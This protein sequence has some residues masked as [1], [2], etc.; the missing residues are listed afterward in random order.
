MASTQQTPFRFGHYIVLEVLGE[1]SFGTVAKCI[2]TQTLEVVAIKALKPRSNVNNEVEMLREVR[3]SQ[4]DKYNIVRFIEYFSD[5]D[6]KCIAFETLDKS[7]YQFIEDRNRTL[8]L[9]E[10]R[11]ITQQLL[12]AFDSLKTAGIMHADLK[13]DNVMLVNHS[14][15]PF[16]VKLIDF[17]LAGFTKFMN[18]HKTFQPCEFR[19]LEATLGYK[20]TEAID[21]WSLGCTLGVCF[22]GS[23]LFSDD[24]AYN[25][26]RSIVKLL[27]LPN[28]KVLLEG[29]KAKKFFTAT[30]DM[31]EWRLKSPAEYR[32][33]EEHLFNWRKVHNN[34]EHRDRTAFADLMKKLLDL[35]PDTRITPREALHH[36]FVTM[37][38]LVGDNSEYSQ[39]ARSLMAVA[40]KGSTTVFDLTPQATPNLDFPQTPALKDIDQIWDE[41]L[42]HE[43][44]CASQK[45][46]NLAS[47][48]LNIQPNLPI[49]STSN[50][51]FEDS[52]KIQTDTWDEPLFSLEI[53]GTQILQSMD[54][55]IPDP[56]MNITKDI[57]FDNWDEPLC[58]EQTNGTQDIFNPKN[59]TR[60]A[61]IFCTEETD[62][63]HTHQ[64]MDNNDPDP[65]KNTTEKIQT[66]IWDEPLFSTEDTSGTQIL[67]CMDNGIPDPMNT[68]TDIQCDNWDE[69]LCFDETNGTQVIL[70]P[71][72]TT[73]EDIQPEIWDGYYALKKQIELEHFSA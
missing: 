44:I 43:E 66:A 37:E 17:G 36:P 28:S 51:G 12:V 6:S 19:A 40:L 26:V 21:M 68:T 41:P 56:P 72:N 16:K 57:Q 53:S 5:Q 71:K 52:D 45:S 46:S 64:C 48:I 4:P 7:L 67:Q 18:F 13:P 60:E 59:T 25:N 63:A 1:G 10:L 42:N 20:V 62:R 23:L 69:P 61:D 73:R 54:N 34:A 70:N 9:S 49:T 31:N 58:F 39:K 47:N 3:A 32:A 55:N 14:H 35:D 24:S 11:P 27:G 8:S 30:D 33:A 65:Q 38:H 50:S 15:Q 29:E 2:H 22:T